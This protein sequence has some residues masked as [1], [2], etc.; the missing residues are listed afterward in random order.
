MLYNPYAKKKG[1]KRPRPPHWSQSPARSVVSRNV[2][3]S[4][5]AGSQNP[6]ANATRHS[7]PIA[8]ATSSTPLPS[9][10]PVEANC[11]PQSPSLHKFQIGDNKLSSTTSMVSASNHPTKPYA[12]KS[13]KDTVTDVKKNRSSPTRNSTFASIRPPSWNS[14]SNPQIETTKDISMEQKVE[15]PGEESLPKEIQYTKD[16]IRPIKDQYRQLLV[17]NAKLTQ[18]LLNG[19]KLFSHQKRAILQGLMKRRMILALDMGLGK[20]L[21]GCVWSRSFKLSFKH[22]K[23]FVICP[24]SLK[25]EWKRTAENAT[26]LKVE[27]GKDA[28]VMDSLDMR[29]C[30][31][32][33]VPTM[34]DSSAQHFV[35]VFDEA[36]SMQSMQAARTKDALKLVSNQR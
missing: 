17:N 12:S 24:V 10:K 19:W 4:N 34:V 28:T 5:Q 27:E 14:N 3:I 23:I 11:G 6:Y 8:R 26:G 30:G 13:N 25:E 36:H 9:N 1:E 29:I 18:P 2:P 22:L 31:W 32:S 20:T 33:K 15:L 35:V 16:H 7:S 21:I